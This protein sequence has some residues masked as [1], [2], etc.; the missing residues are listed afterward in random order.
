MR[1]CVDVAD[2][3]L[4]TEPFSVTVCAAGLP[5]RKPEPVSSST[6]PAVAVVGVTENKYGVREET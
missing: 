5:G 2:V 4:H 3:T 1:T 6:A